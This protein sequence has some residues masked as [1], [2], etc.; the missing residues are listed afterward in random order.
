MGSGQRDKRTS[1][2]GAIVLVTRNLN[3]RPRCRNAASCAALGSFIIIKHQAVTQ[4][5]KYPD[6]LQFLIRTG[7][8][9]RLQSCLRHS[10]ELLVSLTTGQELSEFP[11]PPT[12]LV[13][14]SGAPM[15]QEIE[16]SDRTGPN[17]SKFV[18]FSKLL[19]GKQA[20]CVN[21]FTRWFVCGDCVRHCTRFHASWMRSETLPRSWKC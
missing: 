5:R 16:L 1:Y 17:R 19:D 10:S 3:V 15:N 12:N 7:P 13:V 9:Q 8:M 2:L 14:T 20:V 21:R 6:V 11:I 4:G 18:N